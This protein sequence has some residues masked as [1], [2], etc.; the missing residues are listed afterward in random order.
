LRE[1]AAQTHHSTARQAAQLAQ[2]AEVKHLLLGHFSSRYKSLGPLLDE[3]HTVF[4]TAE[5]ATEGLTVSL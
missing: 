4:P 1:R 3:A 5:L 2:A